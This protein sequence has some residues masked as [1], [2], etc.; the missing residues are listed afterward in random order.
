MARAIGVHVAFNH[1]PRMA[2]ALP[3][4][5]FA[6]VVTARDALTQRLQANVHVVTGYM[7]DHITAESATM[8]S[9]VI[10]TTI[11]SRAPY[12]GFEEFGTRFRPGH[13]RITDTVVA[14][15]DA[16]AAAVAAAIREAL[17]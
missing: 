4:R 2:A 7:R 16:Y 15:R 10:T 9:G 11:Q 8:R 6:G 14:S 3:L 1:L 13:H 5:T 17:R 12:S